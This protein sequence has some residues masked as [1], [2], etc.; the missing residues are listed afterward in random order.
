MAYNL[1]YL[2]S[3]TTAAPNVLNVPDNVVTP[4]A[5]ITLPGKNYLGYGSIVD[6]TLLSIVENF[7]KDAGGPISPIKG[8]I[9]YDDANTALR[10]N[11]SGN[12]LA[13]IWARVAEYG[14]NIVAD[15]VTA[16][17]IDTG[18]ITANNGNIGNLTTGNANI[19][20]GNIQGN[21][22]GTLFYKTTFNASGSGVAPGSIYDASANMIIS[23]NTVGAA[24]GNSSGWANVGLGPVPNSNV[25]IT[26]GTNGQYLQTDGTG[27][28]TWSTIST[29]TLS[30]G[31]SNVDVAA[32]GNV[33]VGV[34][35]APSVLTVTATGINVAGTI[36]GTGNANLGNIGATGGFF[37]YV[38]GDGGNLSNIQGANVIGNVT[39]AITSNFANFAGNITVAAQPNITSVGTLTSL[40]VLGNA[41]VGNIGAAGGI[42]TYV[43]GDGGNLSNIQGANV[44]GNVTSA[45]TANFANFAGNITVAAQ[46]NITSVGTLTS[47]A[48]T[49]NVDAGNLNTGGRVVAVGNVDGG[50]IN[51]GG[52]VVAAGNLNT[53]GRVVA[54]GN[55][56]GGN[57]N[58]GGNVVAAGN[59][60]AD[61]GFISNSLS[62]RTGPL[63]LTASG[64]SNITLA[65]GT[66]NINLS[67]MTNITN[68]KDPVNAQDAATKI[69]VDALV[70]GLKP[71][72]SVNCA[73]TVNITLA[74]PGATIDGF[75]LV[76]GT[77]VLVKEQ[78]T[79]SENGIYTYDG[80]ALVRSTD[81]DTTAELP[82]GTFVFVESGS[83]FAGSGFVQTATV[84]T[85]GTDP[86]TFAQF[87]TGGSYTAGSGLTLTGSQFSVSTTGI[88]AGSHGNATHIPSFTVTTTGQLTAAGNVAVTANAETLLGTT[89]KSTVVN[90]SLTSVGTLTSL[91][92]SGTTNLGAIG[93]V[94]VTGGTTGQVLST[95]GSGVLSWATASS[96][97]VSATAPTS[98]TAG[99]LW[100][101]DTTGLL[102]IW[103][104]TAW[105]LVND[106]ITVADTAPATPFNGQVWYDSLTTFRAFVWSSTAAAWVDLSPAGAGGVHTDIDAVTV[107]SATA[108]YAVNDLVGYAGG[109]YKRLVAGTTAAIPSTD[110]TNWSS[111]GGG[112][113]TSAQV[114]AATAGLAVGAVGTYAFLRAGG[115]AG[116]IAVGSSVAA[117][118]LF[119]TNAA[120]ADAGGQPSGTWRL[121]GYI[122]D[123]MGTVST[124]SLFL[125]IA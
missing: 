48:V 101:N 29:S 75:T 118:S 79:Q 24:S 1:F 122:N 81:A 31:T 94:T 116:F 9:W 76:T 23:W 111:L 67:T 64:T 16:N 21:I 3:G 119:Y 33:T 43:T 110:T 78:T 50:N 84:T 114:G 32:S 30:N 70:Q 96:V 106:W 113:V 5:G 63:T 42:F 56:D 39:S 57:L 61:T 83:T 71:K 15:G 26:G 97:S 120:G 41:N 8:Q 90:S 103:N 121:M 69:Y 54:V 58:T 2:N 124:S 91:A 95:N 82:D 102:Q 85:L 51:T 93:N 123:S 66:G 80:T 13:P 36:N 62:T 104:S 44:N 17:T 68:V 99:T 117:G 12:S 89:L 34:A 37:T 25:K 88:A 60:Q 18:N 52:N 4:I 98:P 112:A 14:G 45:I 27:T 92:V 74:T 40:A 108:V 19:S 86:V 20:G 49:G 38:T 28:L 7:A 107:W 105:K 53:G 115:V 72:A 46:P 11:I 55:V 87:S 35:G 47:L 77:R 22:G 10:Y 59:I 100:Y 65:T 109:I 73:T 6:Q 125:R